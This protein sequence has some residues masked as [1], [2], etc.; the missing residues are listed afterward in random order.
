MAQ[1]LVS[2][3]WVLMMVIGTGLQSVECVVDLMDCMLEIPQ[4]AQWVRPLVPE[5]AV[6]L[7]TVSELAKDS[8]L[9]SSKVRNLDLG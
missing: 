8:S 9:V 3:S 7:A 1:K 4:V 6:E 5:T 2:M